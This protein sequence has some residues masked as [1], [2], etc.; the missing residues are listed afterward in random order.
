[1]SN[2]RLIGGAFMGGE[3]GLKRGGKAPLDPCEW[4]PTRDAPATRFGAPTTLESRRLRSRWLGP[5]TPTRASRRTHARRGA[6]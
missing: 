2:S 4:D 6:A 1:M 5:S 3:E